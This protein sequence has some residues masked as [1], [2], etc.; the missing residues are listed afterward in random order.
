MV[1]GQVWVF[2]IL[3]QSCL[4]APGFFHM[5]QAHAGELSDMVLP[6]GL[7][8]NE[9]WASLGI[10]YGDGIPRLLGNRGSILFTAVG[11]NHRTDLDGCN[12]GKHF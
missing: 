7:K 4:S 12:S 2:Q 3:S 6:T 11:T 8:S 5:G 10:G 1:V 9:R